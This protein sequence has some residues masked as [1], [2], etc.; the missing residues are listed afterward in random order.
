MIFFEIYNFLSSAMLNI[1]STIDSDF[2]VAVFFPVAA[3]KIKINPKN[4][5]WRFEKLTKIE[6]Y[7]TFP[8]I[9]DP[10]YCSTT[11]EVIYEDW[12]S[13]K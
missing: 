12:N 3:L 10:I 1:L 5:F 11:S 13:F 4:S 2:K 7:Y 6:L 9:S 8:S